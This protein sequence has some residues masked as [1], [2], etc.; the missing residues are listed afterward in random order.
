MASNALLQL[1]NETHWGD[2][3]YLVIDLPPGTGDV[4]LTLTQR[5]PLTAAMVVTT[6]QNVALADAKKALPCS[7]RSMYLYWAWWRI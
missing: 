3:D 2:L 5:I 4:Q 7:T 6:P 1:I